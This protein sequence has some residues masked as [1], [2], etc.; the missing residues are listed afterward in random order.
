MTLRIRTNI[1]ALQVQND[2]RSVNR[3]LS[4]TFKRISSGLRITSAADDAA[5]LGVAENLKTKKIF[6]ITKMF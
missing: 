5:G 6:G 3:D 4:K 1:S 2:M